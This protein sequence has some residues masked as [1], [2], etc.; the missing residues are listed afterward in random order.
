MNPPP[1]RS[2]NFSASVCSAKENTVISES[3]PRNEYVPK[4]SEQLKI[5]ATVQAILAARIDRLSPEAKRLVQAA[6]VIG[7][8]VPLPLLL[9]IADVPEHKVCAELTRLQAAEFLYEV[10]S[11]PDLEHTFKHALTHEVAYQ[12]LLQDRRRDLHARITEAIERLAHHALRGGLWEKAVAYLH[13]AGLRAMARG[14][15]LEAV[16]YLEQALETLRHL[17]E[18]RR[19]SELAIDIRVEIRN[20][21]V[22][23]G[24]WAR[25]LGHLQ[26]AEAL[27]RS[28]GDQQRLGRI[29]TL[30]I[31]QWKATGDL[32]A[33]L[34]FGQEALTIARTLGDRS[35]EVAA[36]YYLGDTHSTQGEYSEAVKLLERNIGL[37]GKLRAQRFGT[38]MILSAA[39]EFSLAAALATPGR[40]VEAIGH[41]ETGVRIAEENDHPLTLFIGLLH[42]GWVH[43]LRGDFP[44]A[45]RVLERGLDLGRTWQ[46]VDSVPDVTSSLG[47]L[48]AAAGRTDESLALVAGAVKASR[49]RQGHVVPAHILFCAGRAHLAAGRIYAREALVLTRQLGLRGMEALVLSL[50]ADIAATTGTANSEGYYREALALAEPRGMRPQVAHRD[51]G[52]GKLHRRRGD[53]EPAQEHLTTAMA[54]Y[55]EMG[56]TYWPERAEAELRHLG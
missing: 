7:K 47:A 17:P 18:T 27:A 42:L 9:A 14:A 44:C 10:R 50:T 28:L 56:M 22:P 55:R 31:M 33:A 8:D 41:G 2:W 13:Q 52:L 53:H 32:D 5:P 23:F 54:M 46:F 48:Y 15:N 51:F 35:I 6:A 49:A 1:K 26:E 36:T 12:G 21:L 43:S 38:P 37:D 39:S 20:A 30:M 40:F 25:M 19:R 16:P 45:A 29:A 4:C 3:S 11:F 34:K 24:N